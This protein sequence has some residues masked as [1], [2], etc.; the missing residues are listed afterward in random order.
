MS[1]VSGDERAN[2]GTDETPEFFFCSIS[3]IIPTYIGAK[4]S[5]S[6]EVAGQQ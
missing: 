4:Y 6:K 3:Q 5:T 1:F 2:N